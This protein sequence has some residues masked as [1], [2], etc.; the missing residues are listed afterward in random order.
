MLRQLRKTKD[1]SGVVLIFV[2]IVLMI[3][4]IVSMGI[5]SQSL[6]Q[7][8]SSRAQLDQIV[9]GQ[10]AKGAFWQAYTQSAAVPGIL[11][12]TLPAQDFTINNRA[13]HVEVTNNTPSSYTFNVS[14]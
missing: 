9:A 14:Y 13:F 1:D 11:N 2:T 3:L 4:A 12:T 10:L 6:S 7:S 8:K 5:F